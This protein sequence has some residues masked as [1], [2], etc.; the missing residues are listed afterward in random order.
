MRVNNFDVVVI[1]SNLSSLISAAF[2]C[3][4]GHRV[5]IVEDEDKRWGKSAYMDPDVTSFIAGS[6]PNKLLY[7][8][9]RELSIPIHHQKKFVADELSY[10][11]AISKLRID[12]GNNWNLYYQEIKREFPQNFTAIGKV[13]T[14]IFKCDK[15]LNE[16][17]YNY[18][19]HPQKLSS[20]IK[21]HFIMYLERLLRINEDNRGLSGIVPDDLKNSSFM[22]ILAL[23][24]TFL[25]DLAKETK[26]MS[27]LFLLSAF[28][29]GIVKEP[30]MLSKL[31]L[32]LKEQILKTHGEFIQ[33]NRIDSVELTRRSPLKD[34]PGVIVRFDNK[35]KSVEGKALI[36]GMP[37][38]FLPNLLGG[39][40]FSG[41]FKRLVKRFQ[42]KT[43][44]LTFTYKIE[45]W[46]IPVG[47]RSRVFFIPENKNG[48]S[49]KSGVL[50]TV[51]P[52]DGGDAGTNDYFLKG[53]I[54]EPFINGVIK[55]SRINELKEEMTTSLKELIPFY[56]DFVKPL[57]ETPEDIDLQKLS[58][59]DFVFESSFLKNLSLGEV[60]SSEVLKNVF[61]AGKEFLPQLGVEGE[62]L[63]GWR[64]AN[65]IISKFNGKK[66]F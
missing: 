33:V 5:L 13:Y 3:K 43:A 49:K 20:K 60:E 46:G 41:R 35:K 22:D 48:S 58:S 38:Y 64:T 54:H 42:P 37:L 6:A 52:K 51:F 10:Q 7:N 57:N 2:L 24:E 40:R 8:I 15:V 4:N 59:G 26:S 30:N 66:N 31:L 11:I 16:V 21:S 34:R 47:L 62:L 63:S 18:L 50:V 17:F 65:L 44:K 1:G 29:R 28:Q 12:V 27:S 25:N 32:I 55:A 61:F 36:C 39:I 19:L 9:F 56:D 45:K 53:T 23:Q 14:E